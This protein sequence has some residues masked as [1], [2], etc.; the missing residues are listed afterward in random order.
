MLIT[1]SRFNC[2][3]AFLYGAKDVSV[4]QFLELFC[5][6]GGLREHKEP[7]GGRTKTADLTWPNRYSIPYE[8]RVGEKE[9]NTHIK[10]TFEKQW[11]VGYMT[12]C[13][14][15]TSW[16]LVNRW[17][18]AAYTSLVFY[19]SLPLLLFFIFFFS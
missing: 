3:S 4:F 12:C 1:H 17:C 14:L 6:Q 18:I 8:H 13:C 16:A 10:K 9:K 2:C 5:Q 15:G 11:A 19:I 7:G